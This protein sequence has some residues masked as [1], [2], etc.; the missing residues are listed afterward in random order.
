M[1]LTDLVFSHLA[2][3]RA[4]LKGIMELVPAVAGSEGD[5]SREIAERH[6]FLYM[7]TENQP[8]GAKWNAAL[9]LLRDQDVDGVVILG[10]DDLINEHYFHVLK[11]TL[12]EGCPIVGLDTFF[13]LDAQRGRMM[14][15]LGYVPPR[16]G[17]SVGAGRFLRRDILNRL[18]WELWQ[19]NLNSGLD[20]S[21]WRRLRVDAARRELPFTNRVLD[22]RAEGIVL[23]DVKT[24]THLNC[25]EDLALSSG[26]IR[27]VGAPREFLA[28]YYPL[29]VVDF[30]FPSGS[31]PA[32]GSD[33]LIDSLA[34]FPHA[35]SQTVSACVLVPRLPDN[36]ARFADQQTCALLIWLQA[37]GYSLE[38]WTQKPMEYRGFKIDSGLRMQRVRDIAEALGELP[39]SLERVLL[40][41][42][43]REPG[44]PAG[45]IRRLRRT[46]ARVR[47]TVDVRF[48]CEEEVKSLSSLAD[49]VLAPSAPL[50]LPDLRLPFVD[51]AQRGAAGVFMEHEK[52]MEDAR[53]IAEACV[54]DAAWKA[55]GERLYL[56]FA[57]ELKDIAPHRGLYVCRIHNMQMF[58]RI[59]RVCIM[60]QRCDNPGVCAEILAAGTPLLCHV[61]QA[62]RMGLGEEDGVLAYSSWKEALHLTR[63]LCGKRTLW[64]Q[65]AERAWK[66]GARFMRESDAAYGRYFPSR[67]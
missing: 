45:L 29:R 62:R 15:W 39:P 21:M 7:E 34:V 23:V 26:R 16:E 22:C 28:K 65:V 51:F 8:L 55:P 67:G 20:A 48:S 52:A 11:R 12:R 60:P 54:N 2:Y 42:G 56:A 10:S 57:D 32:P 5:A 6:G 46:C 4:R 41:G 58:Y 47:V 59:F 17:E 13:V 1:E 30:L 44:T 33:V 35:R 63:L 36:V 18:D 64:A 19:N 53:D 49:S 43:W 37:R 66:C 14:E 3:L 40:C 9:S 24:S 61:E 31:I 38:L 25:M 50:C 27:M